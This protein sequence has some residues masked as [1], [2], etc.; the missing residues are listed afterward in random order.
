MLSIDL[1]LIGCS[2]ANNSLTTTNVINSLCKT[3][4]VEYTKTIAINHTIQHT[5]QHTQTLYNPTTL[6]I[7]PTTSSSL[8]STPTESPT[9][10]AVTT[11]QEPTTVLSGIQQI[12]VL[13][14]LGAVICLLTLALMTVTSCWVWTRRAL[15]KRARTKVVYPADDR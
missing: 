13:A 1:H 5:I 3:Q 14:T 11:C 8:T 6:I 10:V 9:T 12:S 4:T 15:K 2:S 7:C